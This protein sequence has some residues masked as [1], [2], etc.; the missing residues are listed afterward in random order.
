MVIFIFSVKVKSPNKNGALYEM[1]HSKGKVEGRVESYAE[2]IKQHLIKC[3]V[4]GNSTGNLAHWVTDELCEYF[5]RINNLECKTKSQR[6][7]K[8]EYFDLLSD[9]FGDEISDCLEEIRVFQNDNQRTHQYPDFKPTYNQAEKLYNIYTALFDRVCEIF[10]D[11]NN[12]CTKTS[13]AL[14]IWNI[15]EKNGISN[16][17]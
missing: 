5:R 13:F 12:R 6:L 16:E 11:K 10:S 4:Y 9:E 3:V 8:E 17:I 15:L 1:A 2:P 7:S 14:I